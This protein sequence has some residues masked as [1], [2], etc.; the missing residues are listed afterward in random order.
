MASI[1]SNC[2]F[3]LGVTEE[4]TLDDIKKGFSLKHD[5]VQGFTQGTLI[6]S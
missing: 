1:I 2:T 5:H 6:S 3:R 4:K